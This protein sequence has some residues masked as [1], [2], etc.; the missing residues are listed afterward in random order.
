MSELIHKSATELARGTC[1]PVS[2]CRQSRSAG[3]SGCPVSGAVLRQRRESKGRGISN[4]EMTGFDVVCGYGR[5]P[6]PVKWI[7]SE[8]EGRNL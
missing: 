8:S 7:Q 5:V 1:A 4:K 3:G 2:S 6:H